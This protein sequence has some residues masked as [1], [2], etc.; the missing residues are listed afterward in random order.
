MSSF[1][2][3]F[4]SCSIISKEENLVRTNHR[5]ERPKGL[6]FRKRFSEPLNINQCHHEVDR[7][8]VAFFGNHFDKGEKVR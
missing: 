4:V 7:L 1:R 5:E 2:F 3:R 6:T 8:D